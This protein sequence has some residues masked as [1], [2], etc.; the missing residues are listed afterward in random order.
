[1]RHIA[2]P[3]LAAILMIGTASAATLSPGLWS[4][5]STLGGSAAPQIPPAE[6]AQMK[7]QGITTSGNTMT[8][9]HCL[10]AAEA[11]A[12]PPPATTQQ[13]GCTQQPNGE[14]SYSVSC[15]GA[16]QGTGT[17]TMSLAPD[18]FTEDFQFTGTSQGQPANVQNHLEGTLVSATCPAGQ[19]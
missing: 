19:Q 13:D 15:S 9:Q 7:A 3:A 10:S 17:V 16:M 1:M 4:F 18:H 5:T 11:A 12:G 6:L 14:T 8:F 2:A